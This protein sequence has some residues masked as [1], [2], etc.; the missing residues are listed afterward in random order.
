MK[1]SEKYTKVLLWLSGALLV[2]LGVVLFF[3]TELWRPWKKYQRRFTRLDNEITARQAAELQ[4]QPDSK[5]KS[6]MLALLAK[7]RESIDCRKTRIRQ[8]WLTDFSITDRCMTCHLGVE[9]PRFADA[10]QPFTTHPGKHLDADRHPVDQYGCVICHA[11]QGVAL[12]AEEAHGHAENWV[13]PFLPGTRAESS[14]VGCHPLSPQLAEQTVLEDAPVY[15]KGRTLYMENNC[16]GCHLLKGYD[17]PTGIGPILTAVA[18]KTT[19]DWIAYWVKQPKRYLA[20]TVMPDFELADDEIRAMAA[21]LISL[22]QSP[23]TGSGATGDM[24]IGRKKFEDLGCLGCHAIDGKDEGFGPDLSRIGEKTNPTWLAAWIRDP[25]KYWPETAMPVLRVPE[26]DIG[27]LVGYLMSLKGGEEITAGTGPADADL[28][29]RGKTLIR[30]KGCTGCHKIGEFELGYN[31]PEH[32]GIGVKRVDELVFA[33]A[34]IPHTL[35]DWLLL[36]VKNPRAFNTAEMPT[37]MPKFGFSQEEAESLVTFLLGIRPFDIPAKYVKTLNDP[38]APAFRGERLVERNNCRGCHRI[39]GRG[40]NIGPDLSFEGARVNPRWLTGFLKAPFKIRPL[41]IEPTRMPTFNFT[42][43]ETE[44][45][46]A[47]FAAADKV[48]FPHYTPVVKRMNEKDTEDAWKMYWQTFACQACHSWNGE[49]GIVGPDQSDLGNR[50]RKEWVAR[51]L[52]NPQAFIPDIQMPNFELYPDEV[53]KLTELLQGF[54]EISPGV[55]QQI[56]RRWEDELLLRQA[57]QMGGN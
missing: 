33:D 56:K 44:D 1:L 49:G 4:K 23:A 17:R 5:E 12:N 29:A 47:F 14:C 40:G 28:I 26:E 55:W 20:R 32:D 9:S 27:P 43:A 31:A 34:D 42:D 16:L 13:K 11:G 53:E 50:L 15:S 18:T 37:L 2:C 8:L 3:E 38:A 7:R 21:Y 30:D 48:S 22:A 39:A 57:Q 10:P 51:W 52:Q 46:A 24:E 41:G 45:L 19:P 35:S 6:D 25:K 54:T 36:K